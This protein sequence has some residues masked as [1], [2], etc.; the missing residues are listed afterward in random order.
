VS[1]GEKS[2][3]ENHCAKKSQILFCAPSTHGTSLAR[4]RE[5]NRPRAAQDRMHGAQGGDSSPRRIN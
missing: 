3:Q 2:S 5:V 1:R 4:L